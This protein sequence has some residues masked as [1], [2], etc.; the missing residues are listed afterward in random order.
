MSCPSS[1][2]RST[3]FPGRSLRRAKDPESLASAWT[4]LELTWSATVERATA[5]PAGTL[6]ASVDGEW[7]FVQTLRHLV[8]AT[9]TWLGRAILAREKPYHPAGLADDSSSNAYDDSEFSAKAPTLSEVLEARADRQAMVRDYLAGLTPDTLAKPRRNPH[10]PAFPE[11]VRSC[12][13]TIL[14][15]EWEH[16]R[17]AVRDLDA[18][19]PALVP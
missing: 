11:T 1:T 5:M 15:E 3:R 4:A 10:D 16:L 6:D 14:E 12:L 18:L 8:M 7:S 17:Y 13:L 9:D 2:P 19:D